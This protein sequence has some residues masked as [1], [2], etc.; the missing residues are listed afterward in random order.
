M[1]N[2]PNMHDHVWT[3]PRGS[4]S[5]EKIPYSSS[6]RASLSIFFRE[7]NSLHLFHRALCGGDVRILARRSNQYHRKCHQTEG[8]S[9]RQSSSFLQFI[10]GERCNRDNITT[11]ALRHAFGVFFL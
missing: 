2:P 3:P 6:S 5:G 10:F 8:M 7:M 11:Q 1:E 4:S 9:Q